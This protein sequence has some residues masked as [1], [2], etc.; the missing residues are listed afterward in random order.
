[1][2]NVMI[3]EDQ[4]M[5]RRLFEMYIQNSDNYNLVYSIDNAGLAD[6][7]CIKNDIDLILMDVCTAMNESGLDAAARIKKKYPNIKIIIVTSMADYAYIDRA[8][9]IGV[10]SFWYKESEE[11]E[12]LDVMDRT[13]R[14]ES[15]YPNSSPNV[16]IGEVLSCELTES[17]LMILRELTKGETNEE[18][19]EI[20]GFSTNTVRQYIKT[21]LSKTGF[22]NRTELAMNARDTGLIAKVN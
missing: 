20:T 18:I 8:R 16:R 9:Y 19:A 15:I 4:L 11:A 6:V 22:R 14:G 2:V 17:E 1:M 12:I 5:H 10:D 3:V 21:M 7:Y 13:M